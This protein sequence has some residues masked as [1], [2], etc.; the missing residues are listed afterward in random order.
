M[1]KL[2][3]DDFFRCQGERLIQTDH[4]SFCLANK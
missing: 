2:F 3:N 4:G 1:F